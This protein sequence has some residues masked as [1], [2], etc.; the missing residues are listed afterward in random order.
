MGLYR[1]PG[2][3]VAE[4][5]EGAAVEAAFEA[6]LQ[7]AT[8]PLPQRRMQ[9]DRRFIL[10][11]GLRCATTHGVY[12]REQVQGLLCAGGIGGGILRLRVTMPERDPAPADA[13]AFASSLLAA[14]R[15][16]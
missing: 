12:G 1:L 15:A 2:A 16:P 6:L 8:R 3:S 10:D 9:D 4:G 7:D 13:Q 14:L 5:A 11:A